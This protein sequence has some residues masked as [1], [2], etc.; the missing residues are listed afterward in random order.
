M[1]QEFWP[2][3]EDR[4]KYPLPRTSHW[5]KLGEDYP[6]PLRRT[7]RLGEKIRPLGWKLRVKLRHLY[8]E[9]RSLDLKKLPEGADYTPP[10]GADYPPLGE[11]PPKD[12][13]VRGKLRPPYR[14]QRRPWLEGNPR[15]GRLSG[16]AGKSGHKLRPLSGARALMGRWR[17][18]LS[19][20][21]R[22]IF[23]PFS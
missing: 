2:E 19:A 5:R 6:P 14:E 21:Q 18:G 10:P 17:G 15:G 9:R 20:P 3:G 7:I 11:S 13:K 8:R 1:N 12:Q 22:Q 16:M 23:S 4:L